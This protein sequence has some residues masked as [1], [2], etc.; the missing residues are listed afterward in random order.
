MNRMDRALRTL[1]LL[2]CTVLLLSGNAWAQSPSVGLNDVVRDTQRLDSVN[3]QVN[4]IWWMPEEYWRVAF[5]QSG[6]GLTAEGME[7]VLKAL[8][9]YALFGVVK[10]KIGPLGGVTYDPE[11]EIRRSFRLTGLDGKVYQPLPESEMGTDIKNFLSALKPIVAGMIGPM[12]ENLYFYAFEAK[13]AA[14]KAIADPTVE[15][16][17]VTQLGDRSLEWRLPL[18][19]LVPQKMC[20]QDKE[21]MSGAWAYCPWHGTKLVPAGQP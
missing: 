3:N 10:G 17:L 2:A 14:G 9:P 5:S 16:K 18:G 7:D 8:R 19:S 21:K 12:G 13:N 4:L 11:P 20:P 15:G 6:S 1:S